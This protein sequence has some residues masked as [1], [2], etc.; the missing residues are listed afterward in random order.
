MNND[1]NLTK[2][3]AYGKIFIG[4]F[5]FLMLAV[6]VWA[7]TLA[8]IESGVFGSDE[9][10]EQR[11]AEQYDYQAD[12]ET[13]MAD[14]LA[15]TAPDWSDSGEQEPIDESDLDEFAGS[16]KYSVWGRFEKNLKLSH[17]H[18]NGHTAL[19]FALGAVFFFSTAAPK[20]KKIIYWIFGVS[21]FLHAVG[22]AGFDF[23]IYGKILA[24]LGGVPLLACILYMSLRIFGDLRKK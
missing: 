4:L 10:E 15:V 16:E 5:T 1:F 17:V 9:D 12:M 20:T 3:P 6:F 8:T 22:L 18:L 14:S 11:A 7:G 13:I 23:C 19:F 24:L 2:L 21:I